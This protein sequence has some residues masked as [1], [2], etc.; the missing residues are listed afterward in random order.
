MRE[1]ERNIIFGKRI[2]RTNKGRQIYG[3]WMGDKRQNARYDAT[4]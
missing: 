1:I 2:S 3:S 4:Y